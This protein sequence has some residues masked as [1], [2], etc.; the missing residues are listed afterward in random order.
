MTAFDW[1]TPL[2]GSTRDALADG[3]LVSLPL[4]MY[5]EA[6]AAVDWL[7]IDSWAWSIDG[8]DFSFS[9]RSD[10]LPALAAELGLESKPRPRVM[11]VS[12]ALFMWVMLFAA[13]GGTAA[14]ALLFM[15]G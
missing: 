2:Y 4:C 3:Q 12:A 7:E 15:G 5:G 13:L 1:I 11:A 6:R 14:I 8:D 9:V 10:D